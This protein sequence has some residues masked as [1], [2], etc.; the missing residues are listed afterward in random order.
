MSIDSDDRSEMR[1]AI[2]PRGRHPKGGW[3]GSSLRISGHPSV[4]G[5]IQDAYGIAGD[6]KYLDD[7]DP[8]DPG[9][10]DLEAGPPELEVMKIWAIGTN[11]L[12]EYKAW[13]AIPD[14]TT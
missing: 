2:P 7:V 8:C 13:L 6:Y 14:G 9:F 5:A 1:S 11:P 12:T 3:V 10:V 4:E